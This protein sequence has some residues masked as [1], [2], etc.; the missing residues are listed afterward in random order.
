MT[1][2]F[3]ELYLDPQLRRP[4]TSGQAEGFCNV[5]DLTC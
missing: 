2:S 5:G 4:V 1:Y 3:F